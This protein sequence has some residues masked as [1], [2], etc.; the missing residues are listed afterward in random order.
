MPPLWQDRWPEPI[1]K[2]FAEMNQQLARGAVA[3]VEAGCRQVLAA[4]QQLEAGQPDPTLRRRIA[5]ALYDLTHYQQ[6]LGRPDE[7][8]QTYQRSL[9]HWE[10]LAGADPASFEFRAQSAACLNHLGL[11]AQGAG[12]LDQAEALFR[13]ALEVRQGLARTHPD[14]PDQPENAVY[15]CGALCNLGHLHRQKGERAAAADYYDRSIRTLERLLPAEGDALEREL[16]EHHMKT[17]AHLYGVPHWIRIAG[18]FLKNAR[19]GK[20]ALG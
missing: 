3:E 8:R 20:A 2:H 19:D 6:Q 1:G 11:L 16:R 10:R 7:A 5:Y 17:Y 14:H 13:R 18:H 15:F 12:E 9:A 4:L